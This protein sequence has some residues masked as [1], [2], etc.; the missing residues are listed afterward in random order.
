MATFH[1]RNRNKKSVFDT[2]SYEKGDMVV[3]ITDGYAWGIW[4]IITEDDITLDLDGVDNLNDL[5]W[6]EGVEE[7][8]M[9]SMGNNW[10]RDFKFENVSESEKESIIEILE[11]GW[12]EDHGWEMLEGD[13]NVEGG[14]VLTDEEGTILS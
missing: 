9:R 10:T 4:D 3:H 11:D 13:T 1:V 8:E 14:F 7:I 5:G 2:V 6:I 12:L